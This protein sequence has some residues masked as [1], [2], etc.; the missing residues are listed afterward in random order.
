MARLKIEDIEKIG[1]IRDQLCISIFIPTHRFGYQVN[2]KED[3]LVFKNELQA[4]RHELSAKGY[5]ERDIMHLLDPAYRLLNDST[6]WR[7]MEEG[8]ALFLSSSF[9]SWDTYPITFTAQHFITQNFIISPLVPLLTDRNSFYILNINRDRISLYKADE[10]DITKEELPEDLIPSDMEEIMQYYEFQKH[11]DGKP[12]T[13]FYGM[14]FTTHGQRQEIDKRDRYLQ[15]YIGKI[16]QGLDNYLNE[17]RLPLVLAG[18]DHIQGYFRKTSKYPNIISEG[19]T[20]N[21]SDLQPE[22]LHK[23]AWEIAEKEAM[24]PRRND[25]KN[26][27]AWAGTGRTSYDLQD[28][29]VSAL[30]GR[31]ESICL[32]KDINIWASVKKDDR[33][34][35]HENQHDGDIHVFNDIVWQTLSNKG[36]VI[37]VDSYEELPEKE[38][39]V[40]MTAVYRY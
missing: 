38:V 10:F 4:V 24:K 28:I 35:L 40:H 30:A 37:Q 34:E 23:K 1:S 27:K 11:F 18:S 6:T 7:H 8:L 25:I 36:N 3:Q 21:Y 15:E 9:F 29:Y 14:V 22:E 5:Q 2:D 39:P 19:I 13:S 16:C 12:M 17:N 32:V 26:Y 31:I 33:L 20:G